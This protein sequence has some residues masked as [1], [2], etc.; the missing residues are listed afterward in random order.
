MKYFTKA[1]I[2][3]LCQ[4]VHDIP[5]HEFI[6]EFME[7]RIAQDAKAGNG[8]ASLTLRLLQLKALKEYLSKESEAV[9]YLSA[10]SSYYNILNELILCREEITRRA[11]YFE[12]CFS[13]QHLKEYSQQEIANA[14][15]NSD[16]DFLI[17][18]LV[19]L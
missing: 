10:F 5:Y 7:I 6:T 9:K 2:K 19:A 17:G 1:G 8:Y 12:P 3:E 13:K 4:T 11:R 15:F 18:C 14:Y 16:K